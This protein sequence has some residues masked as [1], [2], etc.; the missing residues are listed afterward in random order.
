MLQLVHRFIGYCEK[1]GNEEYRMAEIQSLTS[2][3]VSSKYQANISGI[4]RQI[5]FDEL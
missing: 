4:P 1:F 3:A 2:N 5:S